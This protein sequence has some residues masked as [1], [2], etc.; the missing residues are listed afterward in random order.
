MRFR[1]VGLVLAVVLTS[2]SIGLAGCGSSKSSTATSKHSAAKKAA[3][4]G[5][6]ALAIHHHHKKVEQKKAAAAGNYKVGEFCST[7]NNAT[8]K[9]AGFV[10]AKEKNSYRLQKA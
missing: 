2:L 10:C 9:K 5:A 3:V 8:Y 4:A 1:G 7:N 6:A